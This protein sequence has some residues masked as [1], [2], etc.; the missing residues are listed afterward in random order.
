MTHAIT[1]G[2]ILIGI[3][4]V[5]WIVYLI[6]GENILDEEDKEDEEI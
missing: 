3:I 1:A 2:L 5:V 4:S 6:I